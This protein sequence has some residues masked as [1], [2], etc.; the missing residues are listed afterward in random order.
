M[1]WKYHE[2]IMKNLI[3]ECT[4]L[5]ICN[6]LINPF[7]SGRVTFLDQEM[8]TVICHNDFRK[9]M[10]GQIYALIM[11]LKLKWVT[12]LKLMQKHW[13]LSH[14]TFLS[15]NTVFG[16]F[17]AFPKRTIWAQC[18]QKMQNMHCVMGKQTCFTIGMFFVVF[19]N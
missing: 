17:G 6:L 12:F 3:H 18:G 9:C 13:F 2:N 8:S 1:W 11:N 14:S 7:P 15:K 4:A 16:V 19:Q 10:D 5:T